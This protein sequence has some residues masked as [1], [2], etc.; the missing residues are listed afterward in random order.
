MKKL[1]ISSLLLLL[2]GCNTEKAQLRAIHRYTKHNDFQR[3]SKYFKNHNWKVLFPELEKSDIDSILSY[4]LF[5]YEMEYY[6]DS[7]KRCYVLSAANTRN[8]ITTQNTRAA[9]VY[10]FK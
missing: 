9:W 5:F 8:M 10:K 4:N 7:T 1:I 2:F 6:N 3:S